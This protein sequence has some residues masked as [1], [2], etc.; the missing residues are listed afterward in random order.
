MRKFLNKV[1]LNK[2]ISKINDISILYP[3]SEISLTFN[4][5]DMTVEISS[6]EILKIF[7]IKHFGW[8]EIEKLMN[9]ARELNYTICIYEDDYPLLHNLI[10]KSFLKLCKKKSIEFPGYI[11]KEF[12]N[13]KQYINNIG[14]YKGSFNKFANAMSFAE[15]LI[16][17]DQVLALNIS[18]II[19]KEIFDLLSFEK[20]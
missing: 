18:T 13:E 15:S 1:K 4:F 2:I 10:D 20:E 14:E 3:G 8:F 12:R 11:V 6:E 17:R 9:K 16:I 19:D 5:S 7:R